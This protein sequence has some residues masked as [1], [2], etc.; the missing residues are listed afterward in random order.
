MAVKKVIETVISI[1]VN[2]D[3]IKTTKG[4]SEK[5]FE[6]RSNQKIES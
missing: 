5:S 1:I 3:K 6:K 2:E 4:N